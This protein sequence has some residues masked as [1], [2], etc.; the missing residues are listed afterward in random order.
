MHR[1]VAPMD[2]DSLPGLSKRPIETVECRIKPLD[3]MCSKLA[4]LYSFWNT[5]RGTRRFPSKDEINPREIKEFL[6]DVILLRVIDAGNDFEFRIVGDGLIQA[7]GGNFQGRTASRFAKLA[8]ITELAHRPVACEGEPRL[9]E[10]WIRF[11][12]LPVYHRETLFLPL[13][14]GDTADHILAMGS[15]KPIFPE[16]AQCRE[17]A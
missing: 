16:R 7:F 13:G 3:E 2:I 15:A 5:K 6:K 17:M 9:L 4:P 12:D 14:Q 10:Y 11:S 8:N 1:E